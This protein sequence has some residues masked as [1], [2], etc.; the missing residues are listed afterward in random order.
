MKK[1]NRNETE[2]GRKFSKQTKQI[3]R[4]TSGKREIMS[5]RK[6]IYNMNSFILLLPFFSILCKSW[7]S[8]AY[9]A[10]W[11]SEIETFFFVDTNG[12]VM[13]YTFTLL[14]YRML[15]WQKVFDFLI[16]ASKENFYLF[17]HN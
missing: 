15:E 17:F 1:R 2:N 12:T 5:F 16:K 7:I 6:K 3:K 4:K 9:A 11:K 10:K 8:L 13:F 14:M